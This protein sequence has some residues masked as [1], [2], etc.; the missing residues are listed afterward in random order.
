MVL[1]HEAAEWGRCVMCRRSEDSKLWSGLSIGRRGVHGQRA[2]GLVF[3][4]PR[5]PEIR[6]RIFPWASKLDCVLGCA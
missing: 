6:E 4:F 5:N 1:G 2:V 3:V